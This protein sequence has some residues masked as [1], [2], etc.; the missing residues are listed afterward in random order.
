MENLQLNPAP[1]LFPLSLGDILGSGWEPAVAGWG[2]SQSG[3]W[4]HMPESKKT[5]SQHPAFDCSA[6]DFLT[7]LFTSR[8]NSEESKSSS[9]LLQA[10]S[11]TSVPLEVRIAHLR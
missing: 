9:L 10:L 4:V 8:V 7:S 1:K 6:F 5:T 2:R 11:R 3:A